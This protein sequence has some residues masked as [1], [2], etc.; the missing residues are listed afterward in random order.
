MFIYIYILYL[1]KYIYIYIYMHICIYIYT[2]IY[3]YI[4]KLSY[5]E[6]QERFKAIKRVFCGTCFHV[7]PDGAPGP[8]IIVAG[9]LGDVQSGSSW[10]L[11]LCI[12]KMVKIRST[13]VK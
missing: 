7:A 11:E 5:P 2:H 9:F 10:T 12:K 8:M 1:P 4:Y 3:I 6:L 13:I